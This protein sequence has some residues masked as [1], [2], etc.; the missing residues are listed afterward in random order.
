MARLARVRLGGGSADAQLAIGTPELLAAV[1]G[2]VADF[3]VAAPAAADAGAGAPAP[4][5]APIM[6][7]WD[8]KPC[9]NFMAGRVLAN[10]V[11][12][13]AIGMKITANARPVYKETPLRMGPAWYHVT[14]ARW[15]KHRQ[16]AHPIVQASS[17]AVRARTEAR[18][19]QMQRSQG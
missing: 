1:G 15:W 8:G 11:G 3:A 7:A 12:S 6:L 13:Y 19:A 5:G 10:R 9:C 18:A 2:R 4:E 16:G 14:Y 17:Q